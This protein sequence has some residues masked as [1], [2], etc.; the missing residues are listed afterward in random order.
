MICWIQDAYYTSNA[1]D[2]S[3]ISRYNIQFIV[4]YMLILHKN[5]SFSLFGADRMYDLLIPICF[6]CTKPLA[7]R[8]H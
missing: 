1:Y 2:R 8:I 5:I 6:Q 4:F 7:F 3:I